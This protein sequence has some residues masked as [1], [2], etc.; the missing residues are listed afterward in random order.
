MKKYQAKWGLDDGKI[1]SAYST[2]KNYEKGVA[3]YQAQIRALQ[4]QG[5]TV[6]W[7]AVNK[8]LGQFAAQAQQALLDRL[9]QDT[10]MRLQRNRV[11][12]W[13]GIGYKPSK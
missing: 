1:D 4:A 11:F 6:D 7:E 12:R 9:G 8:D 3:D 2:M 10:F 13:A 5:K